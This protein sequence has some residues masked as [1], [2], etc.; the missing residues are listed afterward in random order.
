MSTTTTQFAMSTGRRG[1][2]GVG[3]RGGRGG[4]GSS[5]PF[6]GG[7]NARGRSNGADTTMRD[8][9]QDAPRGGRGGF[10]ARGD[11]PLYRGRGGQA[12]GNAKFT[13]ASPASGIISTGAMNSTPFPEHEYAKRLEYVRAVHLDED[14]VC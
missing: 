9:H 13:T 5:N 12:R 1:H 2:R 14:W 10:H 11:K 6:R 3:D 4:R 7:G 8:T